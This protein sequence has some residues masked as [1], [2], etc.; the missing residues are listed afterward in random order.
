MKSHANDL[1]KPSKE[2]FYDKMFGDLTVADLLLALEDNNFHSCETLV[3]ALVD[4]NL[5]E[6]EQVCENITRQSQKGYSSQEDFEQDYKHYCD[7]RK[8]LLEE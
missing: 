4:F 8:K 1:R 5:D 7:L 6:I 2:H 3:F